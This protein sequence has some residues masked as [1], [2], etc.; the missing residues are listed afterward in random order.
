[1]KQIKEDIEICQFDGIEVNTVYTGG[2]SDLNNVTEWLK[3]R[4]DDLKSPKKL[5]LSEIVEQLGDG[6]PI[7]TIISESPLSGEIWQYG[8]YGDSWWKIG[9]LYGYA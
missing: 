9:T 3:W 1:M 5:K 4:R 6:E 8:N 2:L 7:I